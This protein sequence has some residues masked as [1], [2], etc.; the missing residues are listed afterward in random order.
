MEIR[1]S[2]P[3]APG[4]ALAGTGRTGQNEWAFGGWTGARTEVHDGALFGGVDDTIA[5]SPRRVRVQ[6]CINEI[7]TAPEGAGGARSRLPPE[8]KR[9]CMSSGPAATIRNPPT[10]PDQPRV[11]MLHGRNEPGPVASGRGDESG[12]GAT[13]PTVPS[14]WLP[15]VAGGRPEPGGGAGRTSDD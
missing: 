9:R 13:S 6:G 10:P 2:R 4:S 7:E 1:P 15:V 11:R 8:M 12:P 5:G 3:W 14:V